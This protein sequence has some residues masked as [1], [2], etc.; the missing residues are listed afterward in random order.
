[1]ERPEETPIGKSRKDPSKIIEAPGLG[2]IWKW[3][4]RDLGIGDQELLGLY[5]LSVGGLGCSVG[6]GGT[7]L[8]GSPCVDI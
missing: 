2:R 1:M 5:R 4:L 3:H 8:C 6:A 7:D